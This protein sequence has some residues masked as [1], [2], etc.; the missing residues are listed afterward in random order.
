[1]SI[2]AAVDFLSQ[3]RLLSLLCLF[4]VAYLVV[5]GR[6]AARLPP[7]PRGVPLLG[8]VLQLG[9][10]QWIQMAKWAKEYGESPSALV[11]LHNS[12]VQ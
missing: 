4:A 10:H 12:I 3:Y 11:M 1:M 7:G 5:K 2:S 8:N 9:T 6:R